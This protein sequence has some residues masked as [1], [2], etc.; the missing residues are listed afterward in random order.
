VETASQLRSPATLRQQR[1][2]SRRPSEFEKGDCFA[3]TVLARQPEIIIVYQCVG[4]LLF[5]AL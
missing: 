1:S 4:M 2:T 3:S 5:G